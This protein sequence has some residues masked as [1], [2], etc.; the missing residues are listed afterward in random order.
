MR[1][2]T[3]FVCL[4][5]PLAG[6]AQVQVPAFRGEVPISIEERLK[7]EVVP[8]LVVDESILKETSQ[9]GLLDRLDQTLGPQLHETFATIHEAMTVLGLGYFHY[10]LHAGEHLHLLICSEATLYAEQVCE[11]G[12]LGIVTD[13]R[14][15]AVDLHDDR[16]PP[17]GTVQLYVLTL[18][19]RLSWNGTLGVAARWYWGDRNANHWT[20]RACRAWALQSM[21]VI[22][23]ELGHCFGLSHNEDD[24]DTGLDLM[25]SHYAHFDWVKEPNKD[26]VQEHFE[27]PPPLPAAIGAQPMMELLY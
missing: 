27:H 4:F 3:L 26:I 5:V 19:N 2:A 20:D 7:I 9:E 17:R 21:Q 16:A 22:A 6:L 25:V 13:W 14:N 1:I 10:T 23:H 15:F 8:V 24:P 12:D 11:H 18:E